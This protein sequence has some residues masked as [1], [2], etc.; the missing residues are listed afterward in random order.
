MKRRAT[1]SKH[2][3]TGQFRLIAG[4]HR[5]RKLTFPAV[6]S[7]RPTP[8]RVRETIFNWLFNAPMQANCL[9]ICAGAGT[10]GLE[11]LSRGAASC[12]FIEL[13]K[14]AAKAI[15]DNAATLNESHVQ[16]LNQA[17]PDALQNLSTAFDIIFIDPPYKLD[18][19]QA[20]IELLLKKQLINDN[21]WVYIENASQDTPITLPQGFE[22]HREKTFGQV[23]SSLFQFQQI[24]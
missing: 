12:T 18:I 2:Q 9:D 16:V 19:S 1:P 24:R 8:D 5:G 11:S 17:A 13:N 4:K 21:A 14:S 23:R 6:D 15:S 22:L 10:L 7:L 20:C 3:E